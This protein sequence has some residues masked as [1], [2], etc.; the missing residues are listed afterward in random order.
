MRKG[1]IMRRTFHLP[2][3]SAFTLIELLVVITIIGILIALLLPAVQSAREGARRTQ[4]T[5][6][7]SQVAKAWLL[8]ESKHGFL[9][10]GGW[11]WDWSGEPDQGF[12]KKQPAGWT[13]VILPFMEQTNLYNLGQ[14]KTGAP[15]NT[16]HSTRIATPVDFFYC[17]SRRPARPYRTPYTPRNCNY[18]E[19]VAKCDYGANCGDGS[20]TEFNGGPGDIASAASF[21]W[22]NPANY[23]GVCYQRSETTF[24]AIRDGTGATYMVGEKYLNPDN[25]E[26]GADAADNENAYCGFNNDTF[27][28]AHRNYPGPKQDKPGDSSGWP[29]FG[30]A[31]AAGLNMAFCDGSVRVIAYGIDLETHAR[32][33]SRG[34]QRPVDE[35][36]F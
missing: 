20:R 17:P 11:G 8:H 5:N 25:Y 26:N 18:V 35:K 1:P 21:T 24:G 2:A 30:S 9:P 6:N 28:V 32:L 7:L 16:D 34:D 31:H 13:Y 19:Q 27:R 10:S 22:D 33:A 14:G 4:C 3:R 23:T 29:S 12:G 15:R 36:K